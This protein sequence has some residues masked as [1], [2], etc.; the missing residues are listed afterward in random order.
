MI[1]GNLVGTIEIPLAIGTV[2]GSTKSNPFAKLCLKI[3][4]VKS[5]AD[6]AQIIA[7]VGLSPKFCST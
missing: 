2:G 1:N 7:S 4:D 6:L 5:A 3:L